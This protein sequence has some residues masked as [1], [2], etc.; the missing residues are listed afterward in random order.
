MTPP[1][2]APTF[3]FFV[4]PVAGSEDEA[5]D[6]GEDIDEVVDEVVGVDVDDDD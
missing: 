5:G 2:I 4:D 3:V 6:D 1:A